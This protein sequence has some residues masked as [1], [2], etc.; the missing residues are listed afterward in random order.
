[1]RT[2]PLS[3]VA[4]ILAGLAVPGLL[5]CGKKKEP[6]GEAGSAKTGSGSASG[7]AVAPEPRVAPPPKQLPPLA[8]SAPGATGKVMWV[9]SFGGTK[10][11]TARRLTTGADGSVYVVGD[12]D[13]QAT[14]GALG[15]KRAA[16]K[17]D[18]FVAR[19]DP[20]GAF[21]WV[22]T[23]GGKNEERGDAVAVDDKGNVAFAGLFSDVITAGG[24]TGKAVGS[25]DLFV[26]AT[27]AKGEVQ[28]LWNTG[29]MASDAATA[30][31]AAGDGGWIVAVSFGQTV[32]F[33]TTTVTSKGSEDAVL[34]KLDAGGAVVW[35]THL[36]GEYPEEITHLDVDPGGNIYTLGHFKGSLDLGGSPVKSA[37]DDDLFV[38]RF[39]P[40]GNHVWSQR[41]GNAF[42]ERGGGIAV[43]QA[44]HVAVV[45]SFDK[46]LDFL[47]TAVLSKGESDAFVAR[48]DPD[49]KLLWVKT[50]GGDRADAAFGVDVDSA[51]NVV[52]AGGFE[53]TID[54]G[55]GNLKTAGYMDGFF[56]K[57]DPNGVHVW[58][59]RWG[60]KDQDVGL[61]VAVAADGSPYVAGAY[62]S[63]LDLVSAGPTAVQAEGSKLA[64]PDA[65][66]GKLE[67]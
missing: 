11:D 62:R 61:A 23:V 66:V 33:G 18:A 28:W 17:S 47:G 43:D 48:L 22:T 58:S 25:D 31:A 3:N 67:R 8:E 20:A 10:V 2:R 60:A 36:G 9:S 7:S 12:F 27:D 14:F 57:L 1:M 45:G 37:G 30:I 15:E 21:T 65:F 35:V 56:L 13:E 46:D 42:Q 26:V 32:E 52:V 16:G 63:T 49:G 39:D 19:I 40:V 53:T 44:G 50:Y 55:G 64:K 5:A 24:M 29:G 6:A 59:R 4:V 54:L 51:G 38:S 41:I 34:V